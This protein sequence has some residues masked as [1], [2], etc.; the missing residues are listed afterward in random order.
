MSTQH[1]L[2]TVPVLLIATPMLVVLGCSEDTILG[3][4]SHDASFSISSDGF[5]DPATDSWKLVAS[6]KVNPGREFT[7]QGSRYTLTFPKGAV[8]N[9]TTIE[10]FEHDPDV[11]DIR[12]EPDGIKLQEPVTLVIDYAGSANDP[13]SPNY[14][15]NPVRV[16]RFDPLSG[17][18]KLLYG[19]DNPVQLTYTVV[20]TSFSRYAMSDGVNFDW[21]GPDPRN[22]RDRGINRLDPKR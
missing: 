8:H 1:L 17:L 21:S 18:W 7:L 4:T 10:I 11:M 2:R 14:N 12:L 9:A 22:R 19:F 20:L 6:H 3:P 15:G 13:S 5:S 16:G